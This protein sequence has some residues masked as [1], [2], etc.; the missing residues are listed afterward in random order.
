MFCNTEETPEYAGTHIGRRRKFD[1]ATRDLEQARSALSP[2]MSANPA[3]FPKSC[4]DGGGRQAYA[5]LMSQFRSLSEIAASCDRNIEC[6][7]F[8]SRFAE[9]FGR[10][11][12]THPRVEDS[13][14]TWMQEA[15]QHCQDLA[16][17]DFRDRIEIVTNENEPYRESKSVKRTHI[18][19]ECQPDVSHK[20]IENCNSEQSSYSSKTTACLEMIAKNPPF[21]KCPRKSNKSTIYMRKTRGVRKRKKEASRRAHVRHRPLSRRKAVL[22]NRRTV[23][24]FSCPECTDIGVMNNA[25]NVRQHYQSAH[26]EK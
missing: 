18:S 23:E 10:Y 22:P 13:A 11:F 12:Y 15:M 6:D 8:L 5:I 3:Q 24:G 20:N 21:R 26:S 14:P 9:C 4:G 19:E 17:N 7:F 1:S 25:F 2:W 16:M